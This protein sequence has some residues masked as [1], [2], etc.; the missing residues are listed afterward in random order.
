MYLFENSQIILPERDQFARIFFIFQASIFRGELAVFRAGD[1]A[2]YAKGLHLLRSPI[3]TSCVFVMYLTCLSNI[4]EYM[5]CFLGN[6]LG[7]I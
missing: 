4:N 3:E 6:L 1:V 7:S 5:I 2:W